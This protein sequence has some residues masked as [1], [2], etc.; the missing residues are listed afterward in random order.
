MQ[1]KIHTYPQVRRNRTRAELNVSDE[2]LQQRIERRMAAIGENI[3]H[4]YYRR[5]WMVWLWLTLMCLL[6]DEEIRQR[7]A[8]GLPVN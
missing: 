4:I 2:E 8:Q 6:T 3:L 5:L 1:P 7:R